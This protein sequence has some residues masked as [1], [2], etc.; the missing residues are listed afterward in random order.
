MRMNCDTDAIVRRAALALA[1]SLIYICMCIHEHACVGLADNETMYRQA[2]VFMKSGI[3]YTDLSVIL[4]QLK[5][6]MATCCSTWTFLIGC[7]RT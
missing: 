3:L 5:W 4:T 7:I 6:S 2:S 1:C